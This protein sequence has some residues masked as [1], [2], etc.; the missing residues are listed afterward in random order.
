MIVAR[1]VSI[2]RCECKREMIV[3]S[4][5]KTVKCVT[6]GKKIDISAKRIGIYDNVKEAQEHM[7]GNK[8][9]VE[10]KSA[11]GDVV[12]DLGFSGGLDKQD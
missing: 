2:V 11:S 4:N 1:K 3:P 5:F 12:L 7:T 6:C 8:K 9:T 10:I